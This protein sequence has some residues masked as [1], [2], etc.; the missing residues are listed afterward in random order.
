MTERE[1]P[2]LSTGSECAWKRSDEESFPFHMLVASFSSCCSTT[3]SSVAASSYL[4]HPHEQAWV[5][6]SY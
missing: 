3:E 6:H 1:R 4:R 5:S 2:P